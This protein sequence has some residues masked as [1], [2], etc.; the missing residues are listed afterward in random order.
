VNDAAARARTLSIA[1]EVLAGL[2]DR[3]DSF[4][5]SMEVRLVVEELRH[6]T[7]ILG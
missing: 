4:D 3:H 5:R 7:Q 2:I 6:H 1:R